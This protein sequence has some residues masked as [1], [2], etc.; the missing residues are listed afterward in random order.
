MK[1]IWPLFLFCIIIVTTGN[2]WAVDLK[3]LDRVHVLMTRTEVVSL[4]GAPE[5]R[6]KLS[7]MDVDVYAI[8]DAVPLMRS[9]CIYHRERLVGQSFVF[10]GHSAHFVA[11]RLRKGGFNTLEGRGTSLHLIGRDDDTG[12]P[13]IAIV[14]ENDGLT[15]V[16]TFEKAYYDE[17]TR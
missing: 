12:Q 3:T 10:Q 15:T 6:S 13:L 17:R 1:K 7:G 16:T 11:E 5:E 2:A 9:G 14:A 4:M 8:T